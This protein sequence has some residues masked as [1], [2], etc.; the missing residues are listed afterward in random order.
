MVA[1]ARATAAGEAAAACGWKPGPAF[2]WPTAACC[3]RPAETRTLRR[4]GAEEEAEAGDIALF[5]PDLQ[6]D[7]VPQTIGY[8]TSDNLVDVN[9]GAGGNKALDVGAGSPGDPGT[10]LYF[11]QA[12]APDTVFVD[13]D[14]ASGV[15]DGDVI[16][17]AD[18]GTAGD[19]NAIFG[20]NAFGDINAALGDITGSGTVIV[21]GG[22]YGQTVALDGTRT[23]EVTGPDVAQTVVITDLSSIT[24]STVSI[25]GASNLTVGNSTSR[26]WPASSKAPVA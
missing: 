5:A 18:L 6:I 21:N 16:T 4:I 8:L 22:T 17:D 20:V 1:A 19:Q 24:G 11:N 15:S 9:G 25:E 2:T 23:L 7:S 26:T 14:W 10:I 13:D 12:P 3:P